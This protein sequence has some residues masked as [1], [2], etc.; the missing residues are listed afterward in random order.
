MTEKKKTLKYFVYEAIN[1]KKKFMASKTIFLKRDI[2]R[3][4]DIETPIYMPSNTESVT[5]FSFY[6]NNDNFWNTFL[7]NNKKRPKNF[8]TR[9]YFPFS[10]STRKTTTQANITNITFYSNK[11]KFKKILLPS[12][13]LAMQKKKE[14]KKN[15]LLSSFQLTTRYTKEITI[16]KKSGHYIFFFF[17]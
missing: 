4:P 15:L 3:L 17:V 13:W 6:P 8:P 9:N 2:F 11:T 10:P 5:I 12:A 16:I 14:E 7:Y 1:E